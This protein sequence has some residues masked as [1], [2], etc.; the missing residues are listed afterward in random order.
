MEYKAFR[1]NDKVLYIFPDKTLDA[2]T[3]EPTNE[4]GVLTPLNGIVTDYLQVNPYVVDYDIL[5]CVDGDILD[6]HGIPTRVP[7][8][9]SFVMSIRNPS[10]ELKTLDESYFLQCCE[11]PKRKSTMNFNVEEAYIRRK[12]DLNRNFRPQYVRTR[13]RVLKVIEYRDDAAVLDLDPRI[14]PVFRSESSKLRALTVEHEGFE[15]VMLAKI[16][17]DGRALPCS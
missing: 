3:L 7:D 14:Q 8:D 9:R 4:T 6:E 10:I 1:C 17:A 15:Y 11:N 5:Y 12:Y 16:D 2:S 13:G